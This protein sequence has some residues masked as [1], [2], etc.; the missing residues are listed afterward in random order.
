MTYL[1]TTIVRLWRALRFRC[2]YCNGERLFDWRIERE[3]CASC[4]KEQP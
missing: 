4:G 2:V 1:T 3:F